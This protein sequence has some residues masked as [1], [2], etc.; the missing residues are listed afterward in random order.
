[1]KIKIAALIILFGFSLKVKA[2]DPIFTQYF[3]VPETLN[4]GFTG[5]LETTNAGIVHR[6]QWPDLNFRV[7]TDFGFINTWLENA[8]SGIGV[9]VLNHRE[10]FTN[11]NFTQVNLNYAYRV[12]LNDNWFFRPAIEMGF[13]NKSY[14]FQNIVL[15]DQINIGQ[16]TI[17]TSSVDPLLLNEKVTFFDFSAGMLFNNEEAW[18]GLSLKHI[19]KPNISFS[20]TGNVPLG[21]FFS[22]N[23]GY[24]FLL[25]DYIDITYFPYETKMLLTSNY[26]HQGEYS[27]FDLGTGLV[28]KKFFFG[29]SAATNPGRKTENSHFLTSVNAFGGLQYEHFKFGYSHDFS[30]SKIGQ[31]GGIYEL[32]VTYQFDL[33]VK[34]FGCPNYY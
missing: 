27:R 14:G 15:E 21:M 4:S 2:Q 7:D 19:N 28:F 5:F 29:V 3:M 25:G 8:N 1:M 31:T 24:E 13:G 11:Y 18:F 34:C 6:T 9:S 10:K 26:M 12:Q 33:K 22:A 30:T 32:S 17:N 20:N 16:G 23:A